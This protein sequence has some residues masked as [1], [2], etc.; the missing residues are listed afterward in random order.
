[1]LPTS[2]T[3]AAPGEIR[4]HIADD[5]I[6]M[7]LTNEIPCPPQAYPVKTG[8][9]AQERFDLSM[10]SEKIVYPWIRGLKR[11]SFE[12]GVAMP[13]AVKSWLERSGARAERVAMDI[14]ASARR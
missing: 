7:E 4:T 5:P 10:R 1:M 8:R 12:A 11:E 9:V 2:R 13:Q 14:S 3:I 6:F